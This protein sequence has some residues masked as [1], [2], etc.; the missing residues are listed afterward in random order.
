MAKKTKGAAQAAP[1]I[2]VARLDQSGLLVS[3]DD[4][5]KG[6]VAAVVDGMP[7][8]VEGG[9]C[10]LKPGRYC[11][12][13]QA[14]RFDVVTRMKVEAETAIIEGFRHLRDTEGMTLPASTES[15][16]AEYDKRKARAGR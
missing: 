1:T 13:P 5:P 16:I 4:M 10:D 6:S 8:W 15:W 14:G 7:E 11:W 3:Y 12:N 2:R 9:D